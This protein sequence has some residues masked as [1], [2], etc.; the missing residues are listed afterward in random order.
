MQQ[1]ETMEPTQSDT[2][3]MPGVPAFSLTERD[4]QILSQTDEEYHLL[5]WDELKTIICTQ[6]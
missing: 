4:L 1:P 2:V 3:K 5:T 6:A